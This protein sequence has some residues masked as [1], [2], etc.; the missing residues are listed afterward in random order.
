MKTAI[1]PI[2]CSIAA[3]A[4][5]FILVP[6]CVDG[7]SVELLGASGNHPGCANRFSMSRTASGCR[8]AFADSYDIR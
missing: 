7:D 3:I 8:P 6:S 5:Q 2:V 4:S 1:D